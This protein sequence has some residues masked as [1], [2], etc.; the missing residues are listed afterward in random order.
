MEN[1]NLA[2]SNGM[3]AG[4]LC[5][6]DLHSLE[7]KVHNFKFSASGC[8]PRQAV[9]CQVHTLSYCLFG[10]WKIK[11]I[12]DILTPLKIPWRSGNWKCSQASSCQK[13]HEWEWAGQPGVWRAAILR[14]TSSVLLPDTVM[15]FSAF[16][17]ILIIEKIYRYG[18][19]CLWKYQEAKLHLNKYILL[20]GCQ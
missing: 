8:V 12:S 14:S 1:S 20:F 11:G 5:V 10:E 19:K 13:Q 7:G 16:Y 17:W 18:I 6:L 2:P 15:L 4:V 9:Q 3:V